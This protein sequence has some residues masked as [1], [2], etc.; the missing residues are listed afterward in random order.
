MKITT[1][2]KERKPKWINPFRCVAFSICLLIT[3]PFIA[4][5]IISEVCVFIGRH[6]ISFAKDILDVDIDF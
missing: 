2:F 3:T 5:A 4:M 6:I 1:R